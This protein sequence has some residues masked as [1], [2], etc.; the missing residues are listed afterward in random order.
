MKRLLIVLV[1]LL[2]CGSI[3][4]ADELSFTDYSYEELIN[5]RIQLT[6]LIDEKNAELNQY[7]IWFD[8][9]GVKIY[10]TNCEVAQSYGGD[11]QV[12]VDVAF[13]NSSEYEASCDPTHIFIDDW[14]SWVSLG[15]YDHLPA[16]RKT[17]FT[18]GFQLTAVGKTIKSNEDVSKIEFTLVVK[19]GDQE[20]SKE[21]FLVPFN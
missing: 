14:T 13:E 19:I 11:Y 5:L 1:V 10:C 6:R 3:S 7:P 21:V 2:L 20:Y 8:E 12:W 15:F 16:G 18:R 9:H 17:A 4:F